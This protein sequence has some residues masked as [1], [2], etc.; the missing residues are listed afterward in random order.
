M[1]A[2][3]TTMVGELETSLGVPT[4]ALFTNWNGEYSVDADERAGR[5]LTDMIIGRLRRER[6][7]EVAL[8]LGA[9]GGYPAFTDTVLRTVDQMD[10]KLQVVVS[11][12]VDGAVGTLAV[13]GD[14]LTLHPQAGIGAVDGGLCVV[15]RV[16][17]DAELFAHCPVEPGEFARLE[18]GEE[19]TLARLAYDRLLRQEQRRMAA[20]V[21]ASLAA[22][23]PPVDWLLE[24]TLGRGL[25]VG[26]S[27]LREAGV[28]A[29]VAPVPLAEQLEELLAWAGQTLS[30][31]SDPSERF[32]LSDTVADEVEFEPATTVPAAAIISTQ[33]VWLHEL[34]TGSP[35]PHAPRLLGRWRGWDPEGETG[36]ESTTEST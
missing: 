3:S 26:A 24:S 32:E 25:T 23:A 27:E 8:I 20:R 29:R 22:E 2:E 4:F 15:P 31:F 34:D 33:S 7:D 10:V 13:A 30:M 36:E 16:P 18:Q 21:V 28:D 12:R 19:T 11:S 9:R 14:T 1:I 6:T 5:L 35:D 17:L